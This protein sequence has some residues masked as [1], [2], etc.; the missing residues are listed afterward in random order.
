MSVSEGIRISMLKGRNRKDFVL[1]L[2]SLE[3]QRESKS[4]EIDHS[5]KPNWKPFAKDKE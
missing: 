2:W 4:Y 3:H 1:G 5:G